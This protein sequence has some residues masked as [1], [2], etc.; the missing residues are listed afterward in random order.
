MPHQTTSASQNLQ[1]RWV[2]RACV[3]TALW[4]SSSTSENRH[5]PGRV[6]KRVA[7]CGPLK[8]R[9][10]RQSFLGEQS[11]PRG[12][13]AVSSGRQWNKGSSDWCYVSFYLDGKK[14]L[15]LCVCHAIQSNPRTQKTYWGLLVITNQK[16]SSNSD[17]HKY[18]SPA[19]G[20]G[21]FYRSSK[22]RRM[23]R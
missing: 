6:S 23:Q 18:S 22:G 10:V 14:L 13:R 3:K 15:C 5:W 17:L 11:P 16:K 20:P 4:S 2:K 7:S 8:L 1:Q 19:K 21:L 9:F 12:S